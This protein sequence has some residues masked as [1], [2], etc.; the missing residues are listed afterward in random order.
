MT[1]RDRVSRTPGNRRASWSTSALCDATRIGPAVSPTSSGT[2]SSAHVRAGP[3]GLRGRW[4]PLVDRAR[5]A[6]PSGVRVACQARPGPNRIVA[7]PVPRPRG[8]R[9][10]TRSNGP[11]RGYVLVG[12]GA[13]CDGFATVRALARTA[14][15]ARRWYGVSDVR[16]PWVVA[17]GA[18]IALLAT[19]AVPVPVGSRSPSSFDMPDTD[20]FASVE[21]AAAV[22]GTSMTITPDPGARS[23]GT[24]ETGSTL[25]EPDQRTEP[26]QARPR[27]VQPTVTATKVARYPWHKDPD[28]SW[29]GPGFYGKRTACGL[30]TDDD[31]RRRRPPDPAV[32]HARHVQGPGLGSDAHAAGRRPRTVRQRADLGPDGR[33]LPEAPALLHRA[34]VLAGDVRLTPALAT[35]RLRLTGRRGP[36]GGARGHTTVPAIGPEGLDADPRRGRRRRRQL[37]RPDRREARLLRGDG[38]RR[39]RRDPRR[40]DGRPAGRRPAVRRRP[41]GRVERRGRRGTGPRASDHPCPERGRPALRH[42]DLRGGAGGGCRLP[43]HG[44]VALE[45]APGAALRGERRQARRRAVRADAPP[46]PMRAGWRSSGSGSSPGCRTSSPATPPT[47]C[48]ARSTRS[49]SATARTSSSTATTSRRRSRSGPRS[50][51]A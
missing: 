49:A 2:P 26:P 21:I 27:T 40:A 31:P 19:V 25:L 46:G 17:S 47:T 32:R 16:H 42:A 50:R 10:R 12:I 20:L 45:A 34:D 39:L 43:R 8:R 18:L 30:E 13:V 33:R 4:S 6:G 29:Y 44:D 15:N 9:V 7:S 5:V 3:P 35:R 24:L 37:G 36:C 11:S 38:R 14:G 28:V 51:S 48:S 22:R 23:D 1:A 41:R